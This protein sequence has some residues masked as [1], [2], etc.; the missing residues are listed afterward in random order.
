MKTQQK[1]A[2]VKINISVPKPFANLLEDKA[3]NEFLKTATYVKR[4][5]MKH[6]LQ[7]GDKLD[8]KSMNQNEKRIEN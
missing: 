6:L 3:H 7:D 1:E 4:L 5:L 2:N 8:K